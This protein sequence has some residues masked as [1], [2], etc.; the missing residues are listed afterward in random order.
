MAIIISILYLSN[1]HERSWTA[2]L[3]GSEPGAV[4]H[5]LTMS[6]RVVVGR[7]FSWFLALVCSVA[8]PTTGRVIY[9]GPVCTSPVREHK[10]NSSYS[11]RHCRWH[12]LRDKYHSRIANLNVTIVYDAAIAK[13]TTKELLD[14]RY[15]TLG[16][17]QQCV[18]HTIWKCP[19]LKGA[20]R[21]T[22]Y[23]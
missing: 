1:F 20:S 23:Q 8:G 14:S 22:P 3:L 12:K 18:R 16:S 21:K 5:K 17:C 9:A 10:R 2:A 11:T 6:R 15:T 7:S 4:P 13:T 19:K